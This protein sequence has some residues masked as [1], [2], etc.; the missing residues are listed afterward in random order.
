MGRD[1]TRFSGI[2]VTYN[3]DRHLENCLN[4]LSFCEQLIVV[5]LGSTDSS[6]EIGKRCGAEVITHEWTPIVEHI[7]KE[8]MSYVGN[9]WVVHIDPDEVFPVNIVNNLRSMITE[10]PDLGL[11][12]IPRRFY[13]K[14]KPLYS[15]IWGMKNY[16][17]VV[18]HK[19]RVVF[20][21]HVH[22]KKELV[23]GYQS[24][25][26][27]FNNYNCIKHYWIDSFSQLLKKHWRY[28]KKEGEARYHKDE[29]FCWHYWFDEMFV[30]LK[31][32]LFDYR[33]LIG[34]FDGVFLSI[35]YTWYVGMS[36]LSLRQYQKY[37]EKKK[38]IMR[39]PYP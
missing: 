34:G 31:T 13:F 32:N 35:F 6:A 24:I 19:N 21:S 29:R 23:D 11:I 36:L 25:F 12:H 1:T 9:D 16:K 26:L 5:D 38:N 28:I 3:E 39:R 10:N 30:T 14:G 20:S 17:S 8:I 2:V 4:S 22:S 33:G 7:Q 27:P 18:F 37:F 15:T